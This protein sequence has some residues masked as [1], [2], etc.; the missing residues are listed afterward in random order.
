VSGP[1]PSTTSGPLTV[2]ASSV[3]G[4]GE[5]S[6]ATVVAVRVTD[7][8][9]KVTLT[10]GTHTDTMNPVQGWAGL[11]IPGAAMPLGTVT[12]Y[13][14]TGKQL[15]QATL[16]SPGGVANPAQCQPTATTL[17]APTTVP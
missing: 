1:V 9:A 13:D 15:A 16:G 5:G 17:P 8:V 6:P 14:G 7:Q 11:A 3:F 4:A 10:E 2:L 12:A